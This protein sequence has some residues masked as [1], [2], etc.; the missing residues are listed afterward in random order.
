[1]LLDLPAPHGRLEAVLFEVEAPRAAAVVLHP[2]PQ[3]GGTMNHHVPY[4]LARALR[5]AGIT[6]LRFNFRGVGRSTGSYDDGRG[7]QDDAR[8][9][10]DFLAARAPGVPLWIAGFSFG[11]WVGLSVAVSDPRVRAVLL[12]GVAQRLFDHGPVAARLQAPL[13]AIQG[14]GD[15]FGPPAEVEAALRRAAGLAFWRVIPGADHLFTG[16]LD[17]LEAATSAAIASLV[18]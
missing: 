5:D 3:L 12:A 7:E 2:H 13:G 9:A 1:M 15:A 14:E 11:A 6:A 8:T 4:R 17:A 18:G 10:L 16:Q